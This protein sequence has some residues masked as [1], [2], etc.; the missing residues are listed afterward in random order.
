MI[1]AAGQFFLVQLDENALRH[2]LG[3]QR[4]FFRL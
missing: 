3:G 1:I 4:L 2:G